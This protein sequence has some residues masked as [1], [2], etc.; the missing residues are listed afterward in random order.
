MSRFFV[1]NTGSQVGW[2]TGR[3]RQAKGESR[4][5]AALRLNNGGFKNYTSI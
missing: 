5:E 4:Q 2:M 1:M 3:G